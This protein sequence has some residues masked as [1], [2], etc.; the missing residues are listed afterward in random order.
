MNNN[1]S[2]VFFVGKRC[3]QKYYPCPNPL[4]KVKN[5]TKVVGEKNKFF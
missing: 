2:K 5:E 4:G 1:Y 3:Q